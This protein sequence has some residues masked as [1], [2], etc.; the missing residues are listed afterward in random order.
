M[1]KDKSVPYPALPQ[2]AQDAWMVESVYFYTFLSTNV[3]ATLFARAVHDTGNLTFSTDVL[4][5][6]FMNAQ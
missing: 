1:S 5:R 3:S 6:Q 4:C 2:C